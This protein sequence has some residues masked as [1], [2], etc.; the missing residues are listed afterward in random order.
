MKWKPLIPS[1]AALLRNTVKTMT[2]FTLAFLAAGTV[3]L[4]GSALPP[5]ATS[6]PVPATNTEVRIWLPAEINGKP[7]KLALDTGAAETL[8]FR[9]TA[10]RLGLL[11]TEPS[12]SAVLRPGQVPAGR[13]ETCSLTLFGNASRTQLRVIDLPAGVSTETEGVVGWRN[14]RL[15]VFQF[16]SA[17]RNISLGKRLPRE[18]NTWLKLSV[19][20]N[21]D[22]LVLEI[23]GQR[24]NLGSLL[25]DTGIDRGVSLTSGLWREWTN[26]HPQRARTLAAIVRVPTGLVI[27][28]EAWADE[29]SLGRLVLRQT[30]VREADPAEALAVGEGFVGVLGLA[31]LDRLDWMIDGSNGVAY[32]RSATVPPAPYLHNRIGAVFTPEDLQR[33][34]DLIAHVLPGT[35]AYEAGVRDG[36]LLQKIDNLDVTEWR[37]NPAV[38][39]L[40]RFFEQPAGTKIIL[41]LKRGTETVQVLVTLRDLLGPKAR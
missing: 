33:G 18:L 9:R 40:S 34:T 28:E 23:P 21:E 30:P 5:G 2:I 38:M 32:V 39:P 10:T 25:I 11:V 14:V 17:T 7:V 27:R 20:T 8:L 36:D 22:V 6:P 41:K 29:I 13:T 4:L 37:T 12:P 3:R 24:T 35:P 15:N 16:D 26:S 1:T 19:R 31:A